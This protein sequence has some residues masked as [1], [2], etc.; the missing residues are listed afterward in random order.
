MSSRDLRLIITR[1]PP[2]VSV[3]LFVVLSERLNHLDLA[4]E[5]SVLSHPG[6]QGIGAIFFVDRDHAGYGVIEL[7]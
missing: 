6:F 2:R 1:L 7:G 5:V 3:L 4:L